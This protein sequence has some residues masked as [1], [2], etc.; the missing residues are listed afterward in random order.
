M[1]TDG[2]KEVDGF[3]WGS[4]GNRPMN[5]NERQIAFCKAILKGYNQTQAAKAAGYVGDEKTLRSQ[6]S[7]TFHSAKIRALLKMARES[8]DGQEPEG[9]SEE[10]RKLLWQ[11]ARRGGN[12]SSKVRAMELLA[13]YSNPLRSDQPLEK[14][15]DLDFI[16]MFETLYSGSLWS[17][18]CVLFAQN[19]PADGFNTPE[20]AALRGYRMPQRAW[21]GLMQHYPAVADALQQKGCGG[22]REK[23]S[24]GKTNGS[25][26]PDACATRSG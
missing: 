12:P 18:M 3:D 26:R 11:E 9:T 2:G 23:P 19:F 16:R 6:G 4:P 24:A 7:R 13:K 10:L 5:A 15:S 20:T 17:A 1:M 22:H 8:D 25:H 14:V 21:E